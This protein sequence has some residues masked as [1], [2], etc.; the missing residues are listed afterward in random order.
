[1]DRT[2]AHILNNLFLPSKLPGGS[3]AS[4]SN[5]EALILFVM[6]TL[7]EYRLEAGVMHRAAV[8]AAITLMQN[9]QDSKDDQTFLQEKDVRGI[10]KKLVLSDVDASALFHVTAQNA[11]VL[12]RK[13]NGS[14]I[15]E[16]FELSPT[17]ASVFT[18]DRLVRR[19]PATAIR[20]H[21]DVF[22]VP[23]FQAVVAKTLVRMSQQSLSE[24]QHKVVKAGQQ[25]DEERDTTDPRIVTEL[26]TSFLRGLGEPVHVD[27]VCKNTREEVLWKK[28]KLPWRRSALWTLIRVS[29]QLTMTRISG[30]SA[31]TYKCFM[32]FLLARSLDK[33]VE[34]GIANDLLHVM[35]A[36][37][38]R[39]LN[40]L[41]NP[42]YGVWMDSIDGAVSNAKEHIY[43]SWQHIQRCN[44]P[45]L[46]MTAISMLK[47]EN[48]DCISLK[49]LDEFELS[50]SDRKDKKQ[51]DFRPRAG[52]WLLDASRLPD[53]RGETPSAYM[54]SHLAAVEDW[55]SSTNLDCWMTRHN[56]PI[57]SLALVCELIRKYHGVASKFYDQRPEGLSRMFLAI[58]QLWIAADKAAT[59]SIPLLRRYDPEIPAQEFQALLL[60]S[61]WDL[62]RLQDAEEYLNKRQTFATAQKTPRIFDSFGCETSFQVLYAKGSAAH[63]D[64]KHRIESE[65]AWDR[66][67]KRIEFENGKAEYND[68]MNRYDRG[69]CQQIHMTRHG[70]PYSQHDRNC[71]RCAL[72]ARA[73]DLA[74][75]VHE[76]P[77]PENASEAWATVFEADVPPVFGH[78]RDTTLYLLVDV[79]GCKNSLTER[80]ETDYNL[81]SSGGLQF[82]APAKQNWRVHLLSQTK[83]HIVT[84][85]RE[86]R[87][88]SCS[89]SHVCLNNGLRLCYVDGIHKVCL[90]RILPSS[91]LSDCCTLQLPER[92]QALQRFIQRTRLEPDGQPPNEVIA[93]QSQ[94]PSHMTL[95]EYNALAALPFGHRTQW[96]NVLAQLAM[97]EVDLNKAETAIVLLQITLQAGPNSSKS[98]VRRSHERLLDVQFGRRMH[99][100]LLS[101]VSCRSEN[102]ESCIALWAC[103][104]LTARL[105]SMAEDSLSCLFLDL[106]RRCRDISRE[107]LSTLRQR[108]DSASDDQ[109]RIEDKHLILDVCLLLVESFNV[110]D[111]FLRQILLEPEQ[112][113]LFVE[114]SVIIYNN[115]NLLNE[116]AQSLQRVMHDRWTYTLHRARPVLVS[117]LRVNRGGGFLDTAIKGLW[118]A[119]T[120]EAGWS[121][122]SSTCHWL[123]TTCEKSL[124]H[125]D[126]L[127]GQLLVNGRPLAHLPREYEAHADY[128]KLFK[129]SVLE[130]MPSPLPSL[131]FCSIHAIEGHSVHIG[132]QKTQLSDDW[133]LL[134]RLEKAG[135]THELVPRRVLVGRLPNSFVENFVHWYNCETHTIEFRD[136]KDPWTLREDSWRLEQCGSVWKLRQGEH[137]SLLDPGSCSARKIAEVLSPLESSLEIHMCLNRDTGTVSIELPRLQL[138]FQ[139]K[140]GEPTI[141]SRQFLGMHI[142]ADQTIGT[143]VGFRSKLI[144][145]DSK[146]AQIRKVIIPRGDVT[147]ESE[148]YGSGDTHVKA[149]V[150][151]GSARRVE[152]YEVDSLLCRLKDNGKVESKLYL[153]YIHGITSYPVPDKL[154][155]QTGTERALNIL[156]SASVRSVS[157][158]G[159]AAMD[160]LESIAK[161]S[162]AR[163]FYP[164]NERVMQTVKWSSDLSFI[165]QDSRFYA[166]VQD[167]VDRVC[168][169]EFLHPPT[170]ATPLKLRHADMDLVKRE[171]V[172][173]AGRCVSDFGAEGSSQRRDV[174]YEAR[175]GTKD[176][177]RASRVSGLV[178]RMNDGLES[179]QHQVSPDL[180]TH[181]YDLLQS[182]EVEGKETPLDQLTLGYDADWLQDPKTFL[183]SVWCPLHYALQRERW[184]VDKFHAMIWFA[185]LS[186]AE[187]Q[188][189]QVTQALA[190]MFLSEPISA[191]A[192]PNGASFELDQGYEWQ[193]SE[194]YH[195]V[196]N[197]L[198]PFDLCPER[199]LAPLPG[200]TGPQTMSRQDLNHTTNRNRAVKRLEDA[201]AEQ[202]PRASLE[203]PQDD[204]MRTY[205]DVD[206]VMDLLK[207]HWRKWYENLCFKTYLE[208]FIG[209]LRRS[210]VH[211]LFVS[212]APTITE[213]PRPGYHQGFMSVDDAFRKTAP[214][215]I[216][217]SSSELDRFTETKTPAVE[218]PRQEL[219]GVLRSLELRASL[220]YEQRYLAEL[221]DSILSL[222]HH[223][224]KHLRQD[225]DALGARD[226]ALRGHDQRC[227]AHLVVIYGSLCDAIKSPPSPDL[228]SETIHAI[229]IKAD[230]YL[231]PWKDAI[232]AYAVAVTQ[233]QQARRLLHVENEVDLVRELENTGRKDWN[234]HDYPEWLLLECES[235][236]MIRNVQNQIAQQ[237]AS[238]PENRNAVMQLNMGEGKSSVIIPIVSAALADGSQLVRVIVAK[239][240]AKQ[241]YQIL[242]SKLAGLLDRPIYQM[243]FSR[244]VQMDSANASM[245]RLLTERCIKEGGIM[246]AQPEHLLSFQLMGLECQTK[247]EDELAQQLL[248]MQRF[249]ERSA[250]DVVD[251]SDENFSVKFELVYTVGTQQ[252][253]DHSPYR[254]LM[255][256]EVLRLVA[257]F[258]VKAKK[259]FPHSIDLDNQHAGRF[260]RIRI[261]HDDAQK[262]IFG[263]V[264]ASICST[265]LSGFSIARQPKEIRDAIKN[266]VINLDLSFEEVRAVEKCSF[267]GETTANSILL[268]RGLLACGILA[269]ALG[270]KRWRVNYGTDERREKKTRLAVPFRAKDNPTP[271]SE[272]S[273]PDVVIVLTC[274]SYY[275]SGLTDED[276]FFILEQLVRSDNPEVEYHD[277]VKTAPDMPRPYRKL[278]GINL[279]DRI[280]C[281]RNVFP[282]LRFSKG[283]IDNFLS[284]MVFA[285]ESREFPKKLSASGWDLGKAKTRPMTGFSGTNDS[286]YVLPLDVV[287]LD[288]P[289]QKHTNALVLQHLLQP[290]NSVEI[291]PQRAE[292]ASFDSETLL[293][294]MGRMTEN[295]RVVLDVGAQIIDLSNQEFAAEWLR[296]HK[297]N[298]KTQAVVFFT[299]ADEL[300]V[301][302]KSGHVEELQTS[303]FATQLDQC[304]VFLDEAHTRGT[305]LKLPANY[306]AA[307]TL[308]ANLTKDRLVQ[309]CM[310]M[311]RLGKG[312]SVVFCIPWEIEGK[313]RKHKSQDSSQQ[314]AITVSDVLCWS[315]RETFVDLRR[316]VPLWLNQGSRFYQQ[317]AYWDA[318]PEKHASHESRVQWA[319][320]FL[321]D[322]SQSLE[323]H[324]QPGKAHISLGELLDPID[325]E[326][327]AKLQ[328][329][330]ADFGLHQLQ[331]ASALQEEQERELSPEVERVQQVE[332]PP[333]VKAASHSYHPDVAFFIGSGHFPEPSSG[334]RPAFRSLRFTSAARLVKLTEFPRLIWVTND[335][336]A[337]ITGTQTDGEDS[338]QFQ[339]C[340][341]WVLSSSEQPD[342]LLIISPFEAQGLIPAIERSN[343]VTLHLYSPRKSLEMK[344]LD[345]LSLYTIPQRNSQHSIPKA[346]ITQLNLFAGQLYLSSW[347]DY[348]S[349]CEALGLAY[350]T[351]DDS[352]RLG[353]DGFIPKGSGSGTMVNKSGFSKSPVGFLRELMTKIRQRCERI[354]RTHVGRIFDGVLLEP[355]DFEELNGEGDDEGTVG[356]EEMNEDE[357]SVDEGR[358]DGDETSNEATTN[359]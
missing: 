289:R 222:D 296:Q 49:A 30:A 290:E 143:L 194:L 274:L 16:C 113:A 311:R 331:R 96:M 316:T 326:I 320:R 114:A 168:Q 83:P 208:S 328:Q 132:W 149:S 314:S 103:T 40:K 76:W 246:M 259:D 271:R 120:P 294:M 23:D 4:S 183:S 140:Q 323:H 164:R 231:R 324:Y 57:I 283:A 58:I 89:L 352:V 180:V 275:Y 134:V 300:L 136:S 255:I 161:L 193:A 121:V 266:Y 342:R 252:P 47:V 80:T 265:G 188:D 338:D 148:D 2:F 203:A 239:P 13:I 19:F 345:H 325:E 212:P 10:L 301:L 233:V 211:S 18:C 313:I 95:S 195:V 318:H 64:L 35:T 71:H 156:N 85:R 98:S 217:S 166:V 216:Q 209:C 210:Q 333:A 92:S 356:S 308:G 191:I 354:E 9:L 51:P 298:D 117:K 236:I 1:M 159:Q 207:P 167:L 341:Q 200:E 131:H 142:D 234:P 126:I 248:D 135:S 272:F 27:G 14:V 128:R 270:Q 174:G 302:D 319:Q 118:P 21:L 256:Q 171:I 67:Q 175:D 178:S 240:Q 198:L 226:A 238:P 189:E 282:H 163:S 72:V 310:R 20:V 258:C 90:G 176:I 152:G 349:V 330:C 306:R 355:G 315:I 276:L 199:Y 6:D 221:N 337:T 297:D 170:T 257:Q 348:V 141:R 224:G 158:L 112:S 44:E 36:K 192:I 101:S 55:I 115:A 154:T 42:Q 125:L 91:A 162:P 359:A 303:P 287:Q 79:L 202:W 286:R 94:C 151:Y 8:E 227:Q 82:H 206:Q 235:G 241:M 184:V 264:A 105:L 116:T 353:P 124:V 99:E 304:L 68:L 59:R 81:W 253:V 307:V 78:W 230:C 336:S 263:Q 267:W 254:W 249:F 144:L 220:G 119:F 243:P 343:T 88:G 244:A 179:L 34:M 292:Q 295:T 107:W 225:E 321:E 288:L 147:Y 187:K 232:I 63:Q 11:G 309:A 182:N 33:A 245:I 17:N 347:D 346:V 133:D 84:H 335:F 52:F 74:I 69:V 273:H 62:K 150:T 181:L 155:G 358:D 205:I 46:D 139:L 329:R 281:E 129:S 280:H 109:Q 32:V 172:R 344:P 54:P 157:C 339:R 237:M 43:Q 15:F 66:Q 12:V 100:Q 218:T 312:H 25:H 61:K 7:R 196:K 138:G 285:K 39:R 53:V 201:I 277:W 247:G 262:A 37:V 197:A 106:L 186:Y 317:K 327:R 145:R 293:A 215:L 190:M 340:V 299:D 229:Q 173:I 65:A 268:L 60:G 48:A 123:Q 70:V 31:A 110:E 28:S 26:L 104:F 177:A 284:K 86:K 278:K 93:S 165:A 5:D 269:F 357:T 137:V 75:T 22:C 122:V 73:R 24:T 322:E 97:P 45:H 351:A 56:D 153:A 130:V 332:R 41:D 169:T 279:R 185:T 146:H 228:A 291:V 204:Y 160:L 111:K 87:I 219:A 251:E 261:L 3:D 305:D 214:T 242:I 250:R 213:P 102:W 50:I 260:P 108:A 127:T 38:C 334:L 77:L 223:R 350:T 29:L